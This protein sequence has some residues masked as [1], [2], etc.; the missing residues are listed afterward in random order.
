MFSPECGILE[1]DTAAIVQ[2][3]N[4]ALWQRMSWV[5]NP[6]AAP[7]TLFSPVP[8]P[9][10]QS[11]AEPV[12]QPSPN[13]VFAGT[14][15]WAYPTWK[16]GFYAEG[17]SAK[18]F[19]PF[20]AARLN[21]VEV[22]YTFTKLPSAVQVAEWMA[23]VPDGF[24]F[25]FKA[26]QRITHFN[27]LRE[28][29]THLAEFFKL[30]VPVAKARKLGLVLFQLPPNFKADPARLAAFLQLAAVR[31]KSAPRIAF[32][33][34][35]ASW[36]ADE[37]YT[38]LKRAGAALCIADTDD[39]QTAEIHPA[40]THTCFR[41][42]RDGGY[43]PREIAAFAHRFAALGRDREVYAY[44][45][46]QDEPTGALNALALHRCLRGEADETAP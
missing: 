10:P 37:T 32:E 16:P 30:L 43:S 45:R 2:W 28:C 8:R 36:F 39:L 22:N 19:L 26:P 1:D 13:R 31:K 41:L 15:G 40:A 7:I 14:S 3:Q 17:V 38:L 24:R 42:R 44:F 9:S 34:R 4:A 46:H 29:E 18:K 6:L 23:A 21:S 20:Y 5:R 35:H 25:S 11:P 33:F 12:S 27:R